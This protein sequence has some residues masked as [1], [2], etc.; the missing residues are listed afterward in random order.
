MKGLGHGSPLQARMLELLPGEE[1]A[2]LAT[3][4][5]M[6]RDRASG[7]FQG[8]GARG[9]R[10]QRKTGRLISAQRLVFTSGILVTHCV[11]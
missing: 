8:S 1:E 5:G 2:P 9:R 3:H 11:P 6:E 7:M 4:P 10:H